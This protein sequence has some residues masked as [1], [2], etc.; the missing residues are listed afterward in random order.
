M[1]R[2]LAIDDPRHGTRNAYGNLG[3]RCE[4]CRQANTDDKNA[5]LRRIRPT[6]APGSA[7]HGTVNGYTYWRCRCPKCRAAKADYLRK[8]REAKR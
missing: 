4:R 8:W 2:D 5:R 1:N 7:Q 3:C 6:P